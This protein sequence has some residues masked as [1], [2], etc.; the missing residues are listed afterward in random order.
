MAAEKHS[1]YTYG[2]CVYVRTYCMYLCLHEY[3]ASVD[4][5]N[6]CGCLRNIYYAHIFVE[7]Q[8]NKTNVFNI[9]LTRAISRC[10][11]VGGSRGQT[12]QV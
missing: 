5:Y 7:Q 8:E 11:T 6:I 4:M 2:V 1:T 12:K 3:N 10:G 9:F